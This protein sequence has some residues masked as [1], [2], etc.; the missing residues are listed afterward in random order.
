MS[1]GGLPGLLAGLGA[2]S[3]GGFTSSVC[4]VTGFLLPS[5]RWFVPYLCRGCHGGRPRMY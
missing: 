2:F 3:L 5:G 4:R 1:G